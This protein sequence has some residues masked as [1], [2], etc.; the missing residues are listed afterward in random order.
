MPQLIDHWGCD[1]DMACHPTSSPKRRELSGTT[2]QPKIKKSNISC[3]DIFTVNISLG[4]SF[5]ALPAKILKS[6]LYLPRRILP[7]F[8]KLDFK[9]FP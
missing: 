4:P 8:P 9:V 1:P 7:F 6:L 3:N 5:L 2:L